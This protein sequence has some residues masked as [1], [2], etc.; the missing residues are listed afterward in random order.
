MGATILMSDEYDYAEMDREVSR[1]M[2]GQT[3][4]VTIRNRPDAVTPDDLKT[5]ITY[6]ENDLTAGDV[7]IEQIEVVHRTTNKEEGYS[8]MTFSVEDAA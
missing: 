3:F 2:K 7:D 6:N 4:L 1:N 5:E 8:A